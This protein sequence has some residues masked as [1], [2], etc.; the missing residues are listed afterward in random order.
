MLSRIW[1]L[2]VKELIQ[3]WRDKLLMLVVILGPVTELVAVAWATSG[4][5]KHIPTVVVDY[6]LTQ[7]S[8]ALIQS[9]VNTETFDVA[10]VRWS[11]DE[12]IRLLEQGKAVMGLIVPPDFAERMENPATWPGKV[13]AVLDGSDTIAAQ[14]AQ[15]VIQGAV[16]D[17][18]QR[19]LGTSPLA[20]RPQHH[21]SGIDL[22]MRVWFNEELKQSNY[23]V[24]SELGLM[25]VAVA[26]MVAS[27]GIAREREIGTLE[28]IMVTPLRGA[29]LIIGKAVPAM[30]LAYADFLIMLMV[31]IKLFHVPM[32]G[33]Y[34]L[35]LGI[36]FFYL[37]VEIG[38]GLM[39]SAF[40]RT[41]WQALL[42]VFS[43]MMVEMVFSGYAFPVENMPWLLRHIAHLVPVKHWL[44]ILR[45]ILLKGAGVNVFWR[46]LL[47]LAGLGVVI[48]AVTIMV[49]RRKLE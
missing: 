10:Y 28:Q 25:L 17:F 29:E 15:S 43:L 18:A 38:W 8:R 31:V 6:S 2:V 49:L 24:P 30:L 47:A 27:L 37:L 19:R 46:E 23:E 5:I 32:R 26:L 21:A 4:D 45:S 34:P 3:L 7:E 44:I 39:V 13:Q 48:N 33:S 20:S 41:Q 40:S 36:A 14:T 1:S 35:L 42:F 11:E 22:R 9:L 16:A 12:A